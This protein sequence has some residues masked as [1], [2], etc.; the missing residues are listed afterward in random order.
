MTVSE[1]IFEFLAPVSWAQDGE[2][3]FLQRSDE[4]HMALG[5]CYYKLAGKIVHY[6]NMPMQYTE[7]FFSCK[8][9]TRKFLI[10]LIFLLKT[11][12]VGTRQGS[13][14]EYQQCMF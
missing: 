2:I 13:S 10:F 5:L 6:G 8:N 14:N 3:D 11:Y 7:I 12:I 9:F 1:E 4:Y